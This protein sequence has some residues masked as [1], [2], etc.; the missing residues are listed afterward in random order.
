[1]NNLTDF[2]LE[3]NWKQAIGF[4]FAYLLLGFLIGALIGGITGII[5]PYNLE[6][7]ATIGEV[8]GTIYCLVLYFAIYVRKRLNSFLFIIL[9]LVAAVINLFFGNIVS[10]IIVAFLTTREDKTETDI[11]IDDSEIY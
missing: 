8:A 2:S 6:L 3:R 11:T 1:M 5:D 9:G 7:P 10:L 4:Y